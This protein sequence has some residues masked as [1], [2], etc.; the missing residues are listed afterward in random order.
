M[1]RAWKT[2]GAVLSGMLI[3]CACG[4]LVVTSRPFREY[5]LAKIIQAAQRRTGAQIAIQNV[6]LDWRPLTIQLTGISVH[7][8]GAPSNDNLASIRTVTVTL[9]AWQLLHRKALFDDVT[10]DQPSIRLVTSP[11]GRLNLPAAA[12]DNQ[13]SPSF[14]VQVNRLRIR[15]GS[16]E[17]HDQQIPLSADLQGFRALLVLDRATNSYHGQV[18]Y[19]QGHVTAQN[20]RTIEHSADV[21]FI[22]NSRTCQ[23][24]RVYLSALHSRLILRGNLENYGSPSFSGDYAG[25]VLAD[26]L[27]WAFRNPGLPSGE[28]A[29][30]GAVSYQDSAASTFLNRLELQG[31]MQSSRL[32]IPVQRSRIAVE[33]VKSHYALKKGTVRIAS[34]TGDLLGGH[35]NS[36]SSVIDLNRNDGDIRLRL[37]GASLE[38]ASSALVTS[39]TSI[40]RA[41]ATAD[42]DLLASWKNRISN[43]VVNAKADLRN[44]KSTAATNVIPLN[45]HVEVSYDS[46]HN[47]ATFNP[48][49][50][51]TG[52][53]HLA[54]S[55][56]LANNSSLKVQLATKDLQ[57]LTALAL[58]FEPSSASERNGLKADDVSG[59]GEFTG[60]VTGSTNSPRIDGFLNAI[61][62]RYQS[63]KLETLR[64]RVRADSHSL[65]L[66]EGK[67]VIND[68]SHINFSG[69]AALVDWSL[70]RDG[71]FSVHAVVVAV[72]VN[73]LQQV[74]HASYPV[75]G[76]L[77]GD[78]SLS[79]FVRQPAGQGHITLAQ[80]KLWG[81]PLN[82]L[83]FDF[84]A[85]DH[86]VELHGKAQA[87]AGAVTVQ[88]KFQIDSRRYQFSANTNGLKLEQVQT[89]KAK[90]STIQ[91][92]LTADMSGA[93]TLDDPQVS[94]KLSVPRLTLTGENVNQL[95]ADLELQH[96][97]GT[98]T[99]QSVVQG[100]PMNLKG[101]MD[102]TPGY[103]LN[104][105]L[106]TGKM[107]IGPLLARFTHQASG[108]T[109]SGELQMHA[110]VNGPLQT[111]AQIRAHAEIQT[112]R[113]STHSYELA[114]DRSVVLEYVGGNLHIQ[115][116][117]FK[118]T[119]TEVS[120]NG[121]VP[122][123]SPG[124][125]NLTANGS[126]NLTALQDW[127][128]GGQSSGQ[129]RFQVQARGTK[130]QP[131]VQGHAEI[132]NA[133]Y[134][135]GAFPVGIDSLNGEVLLRG[136]KIELSNVQAK[137]GGGT[138]AIGGSATF[139]T[140][141]TFDLAMSANSVRIHQYGAHV[142]IDGKLAWSG[143]TQSSAVTGHLT[144]AKLSFPEGSDLADIVGQFSDST[145]SSESSKF[146]RNAKLNVSVQ[147]GDNLSVSSSQVSVAGAVNL[148]AVGNLAQPV[149][150]G[151]VA[152]TSG[153]V[154]FLSKR[155]A[156]QSGT[157]A[158]A[159]TV[160]T[161]PVLNVSASTTVEQ[162]N[163]T[164]DL[165][166]PLDRLRTSYTSDPALPTADVINLLAFGQTT[167]EA[168]SAA[169]PA[170]V[171]AE[172]AVASAVSGQVASQV[173]KLAGISQ[174][175][176]N[177]LAGNNQDPG[178]Q[179]ALQQR[180]SGTIL[181][182]FTT[183]ATSAQSQTVQVQYQ[184]K[185]NITVSVIRD[186]YGGYGMDVSY[187]KAF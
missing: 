61:G 17:Y 155:F 36:D 122:I 29:I 82:N 130:S 78:I 140:V 108:G 8:P 121:D 60:T 71:A 174:L 98:F 149:L 66:T 163:I 166:G 106:D 171:G 52:Q 47:R 118:G 129:V 187:H 54:F 3:L 170:S 145:V 26:D 165:T 111:P 173:Q 49:Q 114:N 31:Q 74:A 68:K 112:L 6:N 53:S 59:A 39:S 126:I 144:V 10:I 46:A 76:L 85:R 127:T 168:A 2:S 97:H 142:L 176:F 42:I 185:K 164:I 117:V 134:S 183:N 28:I 162:Y 101:T 24:E 44:A 72:P 172:S 57:E 147:S 69:N 16:V 12:V 139:G 27:A 146:E 100:S 13:T 35:L 157:I 51:R 79:G 99:I 62:I 5:A 40:R 186:E 151:R 94:A 141:P 1:R 37:Q 153:E 91:G 175:T 137:A 25:Q 181:L 93:G 83:A 87:A 22:A 102:L 45:G 123:Q 107:P 88:G 75:E 115:N 92:L 21:R 180:V 150:L 23:F 119:G 43:L 135:S 80:P 136:S 154:F 160:R 158:F 124:D 132:I 20:A 120:I 81:E 63:M 18:S 161:E 84:D 11:D 159:N 89:L 133:V 138:L 55:G 70:D 32:L 90:D 86:G 77:S 109:T 96:Q 19:E 73:D 56:T 131:D 15:D 7:L 113:V 64:A 41:S 169:T 125:A 105:T 148:T 104:A 152:L 167:A 38:R 177:P 178:A 30:Q 48:S 34:L 143:S 58:S 156:I 33:N 65:A 116:A 95:E 50:L 128:G 4:I 14:D 179:I 103:P 9:E 182:T 110:E 184:P 67:A